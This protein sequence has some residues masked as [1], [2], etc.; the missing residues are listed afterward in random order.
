MP[1][2]AIAEALR[3]RGYELHEIHFLGAERGID[4][5]VVPAAGYGL[6]V[7]PGRGIERR[8]TVANLANIADIVRGVVRG[9]FVVGRMQPDAVVVLGG[10]ASVP[11][12]VGAVL[13]RV[14]VIGSE[15]NAVPSLAIRLTHRFARAT[16]VPV[17]QGLRREVVTGNPVRREVADLAGVDPAPHRAARGIPPGRRVVVV[18]GG[19]L[20]SLRINEVIL[21]VVAA[22]ADRGD[23]AVHHVVGHRDWQVI[24]ARRPA[25]S[26]GGIWYRQLPYDSELPTALAAA[27]LVVCR[28]G[29]STVAELTAIGRPAI[30]IPGPWAPNDAQTA[31]ASLLAQAGAA[32]VIRDDELDASTLAAQLEAMLD[33]GRLG[34][35]ATAAAGLGRPGAADAVAALVEEHRRG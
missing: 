35:R 1:G 24:S 15:Q 26:E 13:H 12:L 10:Y 31:N 29:A 20:G 19:S 14:P 30:L 8:L 25:L 21:E 11:G 3:R 2:I 33:D 9:V 22:W 17:P 32:V 34:Q 6:T 16:A 4:A 18:F 23:L 7:L 27:D 28:A 5:D